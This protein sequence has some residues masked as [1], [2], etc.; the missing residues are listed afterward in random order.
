LGTKGRDCL[1]FALLLVLHFVFID[2]TRDTRGATKTAIS[3]TKIAIL[4]DIEMLKVAWEFELP[5]PAAQF[6][7]PLLFRL[8]LVYSFL[9]GQSPLI[10]LKEVSLVR[11]E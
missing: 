9:T 7:L 3:L 2:E 6:H 10:Y 5:L 1:C 8:Q 4:I 11:A